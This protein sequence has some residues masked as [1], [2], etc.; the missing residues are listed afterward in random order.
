[1]NLSVYSHNIQ[2]VF[3]NQILVGKHYFYVMNGY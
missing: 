1:M 3:A 2:Q